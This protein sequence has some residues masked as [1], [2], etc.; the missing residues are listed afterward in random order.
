M[1]LITQ[2]VNTDVASAGGDGS[3]G[4]PY[5]T[6]AEA[7]TP[8]RLAGSTSNA[9]RILC[10]GTAADP[11]VS[12][13]GSAYSTDHTAWEFLTTAANYIEVVGNNTTGKW[14]TSAYRIEVTNRAVVYNQYASHVRFYNVQGMVKSTNAAAYIVFRLSTAN[15]GN[16]VDAVNPTF[17]F[18]NCI[19]RKDPTSTAGDRVDGLSNSICGLGTQ[20]GS[21]RIINHLHIGSETGSASR[22][23]TDDANVWITNNQVVYNCTI[24]K[25]NFGYELVSVAK[26]NLATGCN[27]GFIAT[28]AGS[29]YNAT[30]DGN[31]VAGANSRPAT[32][33]QFVDSANGDYRLAS[34]DTGAKNFGVDLSGLGIFTD[35]ALGATR[36][37]GAAWDIGAFE[38]GGIVPGGGRNSLM[39][40]G[41]G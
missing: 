12:G 10:S 22:A 35:D 17:L 29:D 19:S 2:Y 34:N 27:F 26:N 5:K 14:N 40:M 31:G 36:P 4:N 33:F 21:L 30:D 20:N 1:A 7:L 32:A 23:I 18:K 25:V 41:I 16:G 11:G 38:Q 39:L 24:A 6:L 3:L 37:S 9:Y 13:L 28:G 8:F 15:N